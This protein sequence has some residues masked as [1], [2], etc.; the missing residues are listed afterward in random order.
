M[1]SSIFKNS[2]IKPKPQT[3]KTVRIK[4]SGEE[5][6]LSSRTFIPGVP[7]S[8][9]TTYYQGKAPDASDSNNSNKTPSDAPQV[10]MD[11]AITTEEPV[12]TKPLSQLKFRKY[13]SAALR[14]VD[15]AK[16]SPPKSTKNKTTS[17]KS[18]TTTSDKNDTKKSRTPAQLAADERRRTGKAP[19]TSKKVPTRW[20]SEREHGRYRRLEK[21]KRDLDLKEREKK[22]EKEKEY[23]SPPMSS[24]PVLEESDEEEFVRD[25]KRRKILL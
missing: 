19:R 9:V 5:I 11:Q 14:K 18:A 13:P 6:L 8:S 20:M 2:G 15:N 24:S 10:N 21:R 16:T 7:N 1:I 22:K 23:I 3:I 17:T 4:P 25:G 12:T